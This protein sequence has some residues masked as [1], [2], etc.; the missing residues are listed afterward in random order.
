MKKISPADAERLGEL[1]KEMGKIFN[2]YEISS[3]V[4]FEID[5]TNIS[6]AFPVTFLIL[7]CLSS[8]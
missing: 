1:L 4:T 3:L 8:W 2:K 6:F 5:E 7:I